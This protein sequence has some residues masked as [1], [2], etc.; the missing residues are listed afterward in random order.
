MIVSGIKDDHLNPLVITEEHFYRS[1]PEWLSITMYGVTHMP[2]DVVFSGHDLS[3]HMYVSFPVQILSTAGKLSCLGDRATYTHP[4]DEWV[5][6]VARQLITGER[7]ISYARGLPTT[8]DVCQVSIHQ[9][10]TCVELLTDPRC[11]HPGEGVR[12]R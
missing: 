4:S 5:R 8:V 6:E 11:P 3:G 1:P 2:E 7:K 12:A 9:G 10:G